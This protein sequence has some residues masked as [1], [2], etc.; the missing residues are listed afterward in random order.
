MAL[1][2]SAYGPLL[3]CASLCALPL[4]LALVIILFLRR[5]GTA[6]LPLLQLLFDRDDGRHDALDR[7]GTA[8]VGRKP[9]L[10]AIA[11]QH[12]FDE[13]LRAQT[14]AAP[15][16]PS[17]FDAPPASSSS[18]PEGGFR[19]RDEDEEFGFSESDD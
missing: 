19:V 8:P 18:A 15:T 1:D 11:R 13:A 14:G 10:R 5:R 9:D 7:A 6:A 12:D 2:S 4:A 17:G 16:P 3:C